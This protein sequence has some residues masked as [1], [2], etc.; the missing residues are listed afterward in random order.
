MRSATIREK[1]DLTTFNRAVPPF[2]RV[3]EVAYTAAA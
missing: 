2:L 3:L 1:Q